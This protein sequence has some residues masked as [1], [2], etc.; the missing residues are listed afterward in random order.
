[1]NDLLVKEYPGPGA[2]LDELL[3]QLEEHELENGQVISKSKLWHQN[4]AEGGYYAA[5]LDNNSNLIYAAVWTPGSY[6][7][8][9]SS[10]PDG[11]EDAQVKLAKHAA[12]QA[13]SWTGILGCEPG[14]TRFVEAYTTALEKSYVVHRSMTTYRLS[15]VN[16]P[17]QCRDMISRG[18]LRPATVDDDMQMLANWYIGFNEQCLMPIP[19]E[20][21]AIKEITFRARIGF[22][23]LWI[24]DEKPISMVCKVRPLKYGCSVAGV[25]TPKESRGHGCA[26][27]MMAVFSEHL[28]KDYDYVSLSADNNNLTSNYIY[29]QVGYEKYCITNDYR[30]V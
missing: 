20:E 10:G 25:Y 7:W 14:A 18:V 6:L 5:V 23:Y 15:N 28:R 24:L 22:L 27:A 4:N 21:E 3:L 19:S 9:S 30:I 16:I 11:C 29:Q 12:T 26:T 2:F 17:D 1:M 13:L 8:L